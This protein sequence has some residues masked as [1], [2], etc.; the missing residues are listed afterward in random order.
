M[1]MS[2][3]GV[4]F[5]SVTITNAFPVVKPVVSCGLHMESTGN[6]M[7]LYVNNSAASCR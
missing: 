7:K 3:D 1:L 5:S 6:T 2:P 4:S